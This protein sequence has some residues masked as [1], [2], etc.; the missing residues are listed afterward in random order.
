MLPI[1]GT[2]AAV[3][4]IASGCTGGVAET[5][6][7]PVAATLPSEPFTDAQLSA[8]YPSDRTVDYAPLLSNFET[9][10]ST[11]PEVLVENLDMTLEI[12]QN[13]NEQESEMAIVDEYGDMSYTMGDALG[14]KLGKLYQA[15]V[16]DGRLPKTTALIHKDGGRAQS[17][18]TNPSKEYFNYPRPY[19]QAPEEVVHR[20]KEDGDAYESSSGSY[21][22]GHTNQAYWQG[23][24]L[25]TLLPELADQIL[26][27][28]SESGNYRVVMAM[29]YPL[30]IIGG[31]MM[32][33]AAIAK[34]WAD[35]E[36]RTLLQ[37]A[38]DELHA[39][40]EADCGAQ[41]AECIAGDVPYLDPEVAAETY[42][43]RLT[44]GFEQIGEAD[45]AMDVPR[46]AAS[47]L[48]SSHPELTEIQ[49]LRV[50][51]IT[52]IDSGYP[53]DLSVHSTAS[54]QRLDLLAAMA[55]NVTID[56]SG[57]VKIK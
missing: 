56:G 46:L 17:E 23:T 52:A 38:G 48:I 35:P 9:I 43:D 42:R 36:F 4:I 5:T 24:L 34:R 29:H 10:K 25:A 49:R 8:K 18:S 15:A 51:E 3:S 6:T 50:L 26:A 45:I 27:R 21:P 19:L 44:Y 47:L 37:A 13:A 2:L 12:N 28:T 31:R 30:D 39:V 14:E 55:A 7:A 33:Q 22:S 54:W 32:G 53:L 41:L 16:D 57:D 40:L 20:D 11:F 1:F